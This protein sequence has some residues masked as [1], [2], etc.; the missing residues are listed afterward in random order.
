MTPQ[1]LTSLID[2]TWPAKSLREVEGWTIRAG[3]GGGSRVSAATARDNA[4]LDGYAHAEEAMREMGQTPL[5]MVRTGEDKL[6]AVLERDGYIIK[7]PV[8]YYTA[9]TELLASQRPPAVTCFEVWPPLAAQTEIWV[10]GGI[11]AA[12]LAI[13]DRVSGPKTTVLGRLNDTPAGAAFAA[14]HNGT[15][16]FHAIETAAAFRRQGLGRHMLTAMSFWTKEQGA[17]TVALLV[18][19][20]NV[21]ANALYTSI[22]MTPVGGYHYRI[23]PEA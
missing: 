7:D 21:G 3:A 12:R 11:D 18:T 10:E 6:D 17:D 4:K 8:N 14:I 20:A 16:M 9:P 5:F 22:G 2:A 19:R 1:T 23:K 15:A 13:M